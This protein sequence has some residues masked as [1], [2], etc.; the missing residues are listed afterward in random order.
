MSNYGFGDINGDVC[1]SNLS[2]LDSTNAFKG[3]DDVLSVDKNGAVFTFINN[4]S[5][6]PGVDGDGLNIAWYVQ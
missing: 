1:I 2:I 6:K 5:C 3:R 4:R